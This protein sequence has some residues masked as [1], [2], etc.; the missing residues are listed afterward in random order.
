M[1][2]TRPRAP[3]ARIVLVSGLVLAV[4]RAQHVRYRA[5]H[6]ERDP[7]DSLRPQFP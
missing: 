1:C 3:I 6:S 4:K 2:R 5:L 7:G